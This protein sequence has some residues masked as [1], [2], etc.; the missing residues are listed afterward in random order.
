MGRPQ[1]PKPK[2]PLRF[3]PALSRPVQHGRLAGWE[4]AAD[5]KA[6]GAPLRMPHYGGLCRMPRRLF[7]AAASLVL[8]PIRYYTGEL[9]Q[10]N[11]DAIHFQALFTIW[12]PIHYSGLHSLRCDVPK[13]RRFY[14]VPGGPAQ[15]EA[16]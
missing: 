3:D 7:E 14:S 5:N 10:H 16:F 9:M 1:V 6:P 4:P 13:K 8:A 2:R 11:S 12:G 15:E